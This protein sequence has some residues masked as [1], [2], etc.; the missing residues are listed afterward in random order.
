MFE[1]TVKENT[2]GFAKT[3]M[4][5]AKTVDG[6]QLHGRSEVRDN[7]YEMI[8]RGTVTFSVEELIR[9]LVIGARQLSREERDRFMRSAL[10]E[11]KKGIG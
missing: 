4:S 7:I 2:T 6:L 3:N 8:T 5:L 11:L 10:Y 1:W 9:L